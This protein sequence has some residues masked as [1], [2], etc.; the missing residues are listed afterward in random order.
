MK[1]LTKQFANKAL[2][3][4]T[5]WLLVALMFLL[6]TSGAWAATLTSDGTARL[7]FNM[8]AVSWWIAS[9]SGG[10]NFV[11]FFNNSTGKNAWSTKAE[12]YSGNI[13]YVTIP[14]GDWAGLILTR[15]SVTSG[16]TWNNKWNQTGDITMSNTSNY[17]SKFSEN[18]TSATWGTQKPT[19]NASVSANPTEVKVGESST[20]SASITS[21]TNLNKYKSV[22]YTVD[23]NA[24]TVTNGK[25]SATA[26]G[27]YTVTATV[28]YH[29]N[30]YT[31]IT[32]TATATVQITVKSACT[33]PAAPT[34]NPNS[35]TV[36]S[37][38]S[39]DLPSGYRW[40]TVAT[41]GTKLSSNTI[42]AGVTKQTKYYAE[43]GEDGCVSTSRT[44]YTVNVDPK[45]ALT[46]KANPTICQGSSIVLSNYVESTT[47]T[48]KWYSN[49]GMSTEITNP[50]EART[51]QTNPTSYYARATSGVCS[52]VDK[53][54]T[55]TLSPQP[56]ITLKAAPT[57]CNGTTV[58]FANY[59]NTHT[60][61]VTWHTKSD[62][63]DAAIT[64]A[65]PSQTT[66]YYA[67]ASSGDCTPATASLK[68]TVN[69]KPGKPTLGA[70]KTA[71]VAGE[72]ATLT[73]SNTVTDATYTLYKDG[74]STGKTG[75]SF[76]VS[77]AGSY[78]VKGKNDCGESDAST[79]VV[80]TVC[81][82][83]KSAKL[84]FADSN[85]DKLDACPIY[86]AGSTAYFVLEYTGTRDGNKTWNRSSDFAT[87]LKGTEE[88]YYF[89]INTSGSISVTIPTCDGTSV[90][91]N[92]LTYPTAN[93]TTAPV[94]PTVSVITNE[95]ITCN[96]TSFVQKG[97]IQITNYSANNDYII[98]DNDNSPV[99]V[100]VE[101]DKAYI[102][103]DFGGTFT[104]KARN[105]ACSL[106]GPKSAQFTITES[107]N[108]PTITGN[109]SFQPGGS[110][111]LTSDKGANTIWKADK[112]T[113]S[114]EKGAS[115][116][117]SA[118]T[119]GKYII[120]AI[121]NGC[122]TEFVVSVQDD[123]YVW[124]RK[125]N[126]KENAYNN[127][128]YPNENPTQGGM[129]YYKE[130]TSKPTTV[131]ECNQGGREADKECT[132]KEGYT[133]YGYVISKAAIEANTYYFTVHAANPNG[134]NGIY[135]HTLPYKLENVTSDLYFVMDESGSS[136]GWY[137]NA[138]VVLRASGDAKFNANNFA[139]FVPLYVKDANICGK[140]VVSFEWQKSASE[141]GA[142]TTYKSG[143]G[144]N[145]IR[146]R[147]AGWY[148]CVVTYA[149][150]KVTATSNAIEVT[151]TTSGTPATLADFSSKLPV[152]MVNTNGVGFPSDKNLATKNTDCASGKRYPSLYADDLK[153]KVTVDVIIKKGNEILYDRKA[154]MN[155]RGSSSLNFKK[156]SYAFVSGQDSCVFD[157][158]RHDYVKT[159]KEK[160]L[161]LLGDENYKT[162][163][164]DWVLYAATPDPSMMRNR[165]VFDLYQQMRPNDWGVHSTYVELIVDGE[166]RGV[167]VFMDKITANE[168]RVNITNSDGFIV[169][170]DKTDVVDRVEDKD[171]DQKTFATTRT[172]TKENS[173]GIESYGA[174]IDQRFEI[175]YPEKEDIED[176][177]GNWEAFYKKVQQR[178]EDFE[179]ALANKKYEE[180][181]AIIDYDSWA[182]W[183][184]ISEFIKNQDGFRAS[185]LFIYN[186]GKIMAT[187]LWDQELS[188]DNRTR[189]AHGSNSENGLL[190]T[191]SSVYTD[192]FPAPFWFTNK[193]TDVNNL[194]GGLLN[195]PC[196]VALVKSK[197]DA[198]Q[199]GVLSAS[200]CSTLVAKYD[201][202]LDDA[203][204]NREAT[205]W[206]YTEGA[207]GTTTDGD[208]MG[209]YSQGEGDPGHY[210]YT[211]SKNAITSYASKRSTA[212][213]ANG[214]LGKAINNLNGETLIFNIKPA[215]VET[216]PWQQSVIFVNAPTG[217]EYILDYSALTAVGAEVKQN[218]NTYTIKV[219][220][221]NI[222]E[223]AGN[224]AEKKVTYQI[225]ATIDAEGDNACGAQ[226]ENTATATINVN[227]VTEDCNPPIVK[228]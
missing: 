133:W 199:A 210:S 209:Y 176:A 42:S 127:F 135:T 120:T 188:M 197:W 105:K 106:T 190:S 213:D 144:I 125:P 169:K 154:R 198:Y 70:S 48:V 51:P 74:V 206:P 151:N 39:F 109:N 189:I 141:N 148:R 112:G 143:K 126:K 96:E 228:P 86:C 184:I 227:D 146:T 163:D 46:L 78:T 61:T 3:K 28:T 25:F 175:E 52:S 216:S 9:S 123:L 224:G 37:G 18:S 91:T 24:G 115:V 129:M 167:Y 196:F 17:I 152:I 20:L 150:G 98:G 15:N 60:G 149:E 100:S 85:Y 208:Y 35:T 172:G 217:Y 223:T 27:T 73:V 8:S 64:S 47:G 136:D 166:Y 193:G 134:K 181:R 145:N 215:T 84:Y 88:H 195:D 53:T 171:G 124:M 156:K 30:C 185:N 23:N 65:K 75:T 57:I 142:Y 69:D 107:D 89:T 160:M 32:S 179:T 153:E 117:F 38:T 221:P 116:T 119:N 94:A 7:Y 200:N 83:I 40:Y 147:E 132:D 12:V 192:A 161:N 97:K 157:K 71:L 93:I 1:N 212:L 79:A 56:A 173:N 111:V 155:Y 29:P 102:Y 207:R 50:S 202:E 76:S 59:V 203:I 31:S 49:S 81:N 44:A 180:V 95:V 45:S 140:E 122:E 108:A 110:T 113:L 87:N 55:V 130:F 137:I 183:F 191:T 219:P 16:P 187:P 194:T 177:G 164:K 10:G 159:K 80:I 66:T 62:F 68:V 54:L 92:T 36:C 99:N 82:P 128:Y 170:F 63:S 214:G 90:T 6:G 131:P 11:Y 182:D 58:T 67:K 34:L 104:L 204:R 168:G 114:A 220:R 2:F 186:G 165:L 41:G 22:S 121:Y 26:E 19:S 118:D 72:N 13:Y 5:R 103:F 43:A 201:G 162:S 14:A 21:N 205:K 33:P 178:F 211:A 4:P 218:G 139:D 138:P 77:E 222:W 158:G 101:N 225:S 226:I 174:C